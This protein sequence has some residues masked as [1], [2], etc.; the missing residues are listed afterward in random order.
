MA[1]AASSDLN[2]PL[3]APKPARAVNPWPRRIAWGAAAL[4]FLAIGGFVAY[5]AVI[6]NPDGGRPIA[7]AAIEQAQRRGGETPQAEATPAA[8]AAQPPRQQA[9]AAQLED[10][11]G[12][13]VV[14]PGSDAPNAVVIR[15]PDAASAARLAPAPDRRLV[16]RGRHGPLPRIGEDG[17][18]PHQVYARPVA[19]EAAGQPRIAILLGGLGI[20]ATATADAIARLPPEV[21]LAFAP[22]GGDLE[23]QAQRARADGHEIFLQA[24]M[25]PFDYPD[26]DPGPHTLTTSASAEENL[27][28]LHWVMA[29]FPGYV[30][31]VNFMGARFASTESALEPVVRDLAKRGLMVVDDGS[32]GRSLLQ[33]AAAALR[34]PSVKADLVLDAAQRAD[35]IDRELARLEQLARERGVVLASASALPLTIERLQR[36]TRGLEQRGVRLV[37]VSAVPAARG[38]VTGSTRSTG[39]AL[40]RR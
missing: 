20:S 1:D 7:I 13:R 32:S 23:R 9:S 27:D 25:E 36:W 15:V 34:A 19:P 3:G 5:I 30:G 28:R 38:Q 10:E 16:E 4:P 18:R 14:R 2:R 26:N 31:V 35:A 29:R 8:E 17:A 40:E 24:P 39:A 11:A 12:V 33:P 22:Y 6:R 37:P 21:S